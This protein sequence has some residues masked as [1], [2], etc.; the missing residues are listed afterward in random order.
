[1]AG[2]YIMFVAMTLTRSQRKARHSA[3]RLKVWSRDESARIKD[4]VWTSV[5]SLCNAET[6]CPQAR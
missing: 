6:C 1:M 2:H 3:G 5:G 4:Q